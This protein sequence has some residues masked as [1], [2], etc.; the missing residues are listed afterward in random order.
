MSVDRDV[1]AKERINLNALL[2][3]IQEK[4][5]SLNSLPKKGTLHQIAKDEKGELA[6][7]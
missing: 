7:L 1:S 3:C 6:S 5:E 4:L 2:R